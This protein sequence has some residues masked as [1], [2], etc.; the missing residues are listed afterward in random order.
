MIPDNFPISDVRSERERFHQLF[1]TYR[2]AV[3]RMAYGILK[4]REDAMDVVQDTFLKVMRKEKSWRKSPSVKGWI[5]KVARNLSIDRYRRRR[6]SVSLETAGISPLSGGTDTE[7]LRI[8]NLDMKAVIRDIFPELPPRE[9]AV[10]AL[11]YYEDMTFRE[12]SETMGVSEGTVK[13]LHHR[14]ISRIR[15][16]LAGRWGEK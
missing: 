3:F 6:K 5:L 13:S 14:A 16:L 1:V 8:L 9:Q 10:F 11:K 4:N 7:G 15:K 12:I 2:E